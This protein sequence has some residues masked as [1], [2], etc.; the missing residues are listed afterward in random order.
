MMSYEAALRLTDNNLPTKEDFEELIIHC[1]WLWLASKRCYHI[2]G[3]NGNTILLPARGMIRY[4][5]KTVVGENAF[6]NYQSERQKSRTMKQKTAV[7]TEHMLHYDKDSVLVI[8]KD[9][10]EVTKYG[11]L[12]EALR[13]AI[14]A[15][16][17]KTVILDFTDVGTDTLTERKLELVAELI[18]EYRASCVFRC[19]FPNPDEPYGVKKEFERI[20]RL[21]EKRTVRVA[22]GKC[23]SRILYDCETSKEV[24]E[25]LLNPPEG[26]VKAIR[27]RTEAEARAYLQG[28]S[29]SNGWEEYAVLGEH[30][31]FKKE[32]LVIGIEWL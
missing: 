25:I 19:Y 5:G 21:M 32:S 29:D 20:Q 7:Q 6:G 18:Q 23:L 12:K 4:N 9:L 22:F 24:R 30:G 15:D 1:R 3:P 28:L 16:G 27:F 17:V 26:E 11:L 14:T 13:S 8:L 31:D 10:I 2:V